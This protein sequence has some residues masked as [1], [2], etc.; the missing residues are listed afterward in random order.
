MSRQRLLVPSQGQSNEAMTE[1][2]ASDVAYN[3]VYV[4]VRDEAGSALYEKLQEVYLASDMVDIGGQTAQKVLELQTIPPILQIQLE[5][6]PVLPIEE[7]L[8]R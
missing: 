2:S 1:K 4:S 8:S 6:G 5:V 3:S 7:F